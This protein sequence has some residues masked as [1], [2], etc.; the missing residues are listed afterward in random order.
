VSASFGGEP[1]VFD[2]FKTLLG[3]A[4]K[5]FNNPLRFLGHRR[6]RAHLAQP[7]ALSRLRRCRAMLGERCDGALRS[8]GR[9]EAVAVCWRRSRGEAARPR[10]P[11]RGSAVARPASPTDAAACVWRLTMSMAWA[12]LHSA[13]SVC[14]NFTPSC[15]SVRRSSHAADGS[16]CAAQEA[17]KGE[18]AS[19]RILQMSRQ[20]MEEC[21]ASTNLDERSIAVGR[22]ARVAQTARSFHALGH[23]G[24]RGEPGS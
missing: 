21:R 1:D 7:W 12:C 23:L 19:G 13:G 11:T 3:E 2:V 24:H 15:T 8:S 14:S 10:L 20:L 22:A 18:W 17:S 5:R 4:G 9:G 16:R 6:V